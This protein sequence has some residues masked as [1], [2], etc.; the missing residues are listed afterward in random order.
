MRSKS[1][2]TL[3]RCF[4]GFPSRGRKFQ[5]RKGSFCCMKRGLENCKNEVNCNPLCA[6]L[7]HSMKH[8]LLSHNDLL[9]RQ[10]LCG[11]HF[12]AFTDTCSLSQGLKA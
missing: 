10:R 11:Y 3:K 8:D 4:R 9:A 1:V 5:G 2:Q 12:L 6:A 7:K